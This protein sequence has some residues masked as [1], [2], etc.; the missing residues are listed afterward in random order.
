MI[1]SEKINHWLSIAPI[2]NDVVVFDVGD[3]PF[4]RMKRFLVDLKVQIDR[5]DLLTEAFIFN[6][7]IKVLVGDV[8]KDKNINNDG[9]WNMWGTDLLFSNDIPID[10]V[11]AISFDGE[12]EKSKFDP[13]HEHRYV[14]VGELPVEIINKYL[15]MKAF[16]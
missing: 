12:N 3:D 9:T 8:L 2:T 4:K 10:K 6:E 5:W 13:K 1:T 15:S 11:L 14:A 7:N 16:W